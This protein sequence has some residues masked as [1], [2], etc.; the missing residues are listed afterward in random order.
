VIVGIGAD[1]VSIPRMVRAY[2]RHGERLARRLL[3]ESEQVEFHRRGAPPSFLAKRFAAKEAASKALGT[4]FS[5]GLT[6]HHIE[7][8]N[9]RHGQPRL[10][11]IG[12]GAELAEALGVGRSLL[13]LADERDHA[14]AFV[15][16]EA[17]SG[18]E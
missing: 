10:R 15:T 13:T 11:F 18:N 3:T 4:G 17:R 14:L 5:N 2:A 12:R 8:S 16:L 9:N 1:I 6:L 7:V